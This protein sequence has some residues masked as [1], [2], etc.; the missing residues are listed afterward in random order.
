MN[1]IMRL[2]R[3]S[4]ILAVV[5]PTISSFAPSSNHVLLK[6]WSTSSSIHSSVLPI[7][8]KDV[9]GQQQPELGED[10]LYMTPPERNPP[11]AGSI[12]KMLPKETFEI[13]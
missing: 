8:T 11:V 5:A 10:D 1:N 13:G 3:L 4:L 12:M 2:P 6:S 7:P 9:I